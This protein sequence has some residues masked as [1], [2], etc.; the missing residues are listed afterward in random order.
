MRKCTSTRYDS[1]RH[2]NLTEFNKTTDWIPEMF[3][4]SLGICLPLYRPSLTSLL[5]SLRAM[6]DDVRIR[7]LQQAD[8]S[9][10]PSKF[11]IFAQLALFA[12]CGSVRS[13]APIS[14]PLSLFF[15]TR[16]D[17]PKA[18]NIDAS[19]VVSSMS[20]EPC[21]T[22]SRPLRSFQNVCESNGMIDTAGFNRLA[23]LVS[24]AH[25][26][27]P[28][29]SKTCRT[30]EADIRHIRYIRPPLDADDKP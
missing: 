23:C 12:L 11:N 15:R 29:I 26:D 20:E 3:E 8:T 14:L 30:G 1:N 6:V 18:A 2:L 5:A 9:R 4:E 17:F 19:K 13:A 10:Q 28:A 22:P 25:P 7:G 27:S 21:Q 16:H 24:R